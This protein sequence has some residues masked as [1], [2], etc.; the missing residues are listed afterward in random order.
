MWWWSGS[1]SIELQTDHYVF[2]F[3]CVLVS[4]HEN[5]MRILFERERPSQSDYIVIL[6]IF[7]SSSK[8]LNIVTG[9]RVPLGRRRWSVC[10]GWGYHW[11]P[12]KYTNSCYSSNT[13]LS[14]VYTR[15]DLQLSGPQITAAHDQR[16]ASSH[17]Q[18]RGSAEEPCVSKQHLLG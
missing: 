1:G 6:K 9:S 10:G 18:R 12:D 3:V 16:L 2:L 17:G 15:S 8:T 5:C 13:H 11:E 14:L 7:R 4:E